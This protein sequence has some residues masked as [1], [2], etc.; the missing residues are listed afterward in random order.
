[1]SAGSPHDCCEGAKR[2]LLTCLEMFGCGRHRE[3]YVFCDILGLGCRPGTIQSSS[4]FILGS[5]RFAL[6]NLGSLMYVQRI[7]FVLNARVCTH[8]RARSA[9]TASIMG[10]LG[11]HKHGAPAARFARWF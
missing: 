10:D 1:M 9:V 11:P 7:N 3:A 8:A 4:W 6:G 2:V 5:F